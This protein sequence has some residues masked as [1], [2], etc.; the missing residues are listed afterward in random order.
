M[1]ATV[2]CNNTPNK[3]YFHVS[4]AQGAFTKD[5]PGIPDG[6]GDAHGETEQSES[7]A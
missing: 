5:Q 2:S 7:T 6:A 4:E 1:P 3:E